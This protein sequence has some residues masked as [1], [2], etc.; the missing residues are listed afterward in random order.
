M[1]QDT[2]GG[3]FTGS[4]VGFEPRYG[5]AMPLFGTGELL[6]G[7]SELGLGF[8]EGSL[9]GSDP[10]LGSC[11]LPDCGSDVFACLCCLL[12]SCGSGSTVVDGLG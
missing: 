7:L 12:S 5:S 4:G 6:L 3:G 2:L 9:G 11:E 8:V 1:R 10:A